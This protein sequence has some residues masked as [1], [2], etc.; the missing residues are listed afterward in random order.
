MGWERLHV[1][2]GTDILDGWIK[3]MLM[4]C[5]CLL[6]LICLFNPDSLL[7]PVGWVSDI[8]SC[9]L[10]GI[11]IGCQCFYCV[12]SRSESDPNTMVRH[13]WAG[14]YHSL[15]WFLKLSLSWLQS[16]LVSVTTWLLVYQTADGMWKLNAH[17]EEKAIDFG[18]RM[19]A[20]SE[21]KRIICRQLTCQL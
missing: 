21:L 5:C 18:E 12:S 11:L 2:M 16:L 13:W 7:W 10:G 20:I 3:R 17:W 6:L 14:R 4:T 8:K 15:S 1:C 9:K 19:F